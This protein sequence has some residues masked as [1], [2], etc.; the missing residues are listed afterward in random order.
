VR[1]VLVPSSALLSGLQFALLNPALALLLVVVFGASAADVGWVLAAYN[2]SGFVASLLLP[3]YADRREDYLGP[4]LA[5]GVLGVAMALLLLSTPSLPIVVLGLVTIGAPAGVG[6]SLLF[7]HLNFSGARPADVVNTRA[8]VS[9][10]WVVGP[11]LAALLVGWAGNR[12]LLLALVAVAVL[13]VAATAGLLGMRRRARRDPVDEA[14]QVVATGRTMS[15]S[16]VTLVIVAFIALQATNSAVVAIMALYVTKSLG[17]D[18]IWAGLSLGVAAA[19]EI[20]ALLVLARLDDRFSSL[21]LIG[22]GCLAGIAYYAVM[23]VVSG[24]ALLLVVQVLNAWF[25]ATIAGVGITLFQ[26]VV[27]RPGLATGLYTNTRRLGAILSGPII[28][29]GSLTLHSYAGVF[30]VCATMTL[31]AAALLAVAARSQP[32]EV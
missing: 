14:V 8:V 25:F 17:L 32:I 31:A 12:A 20:P 16:G 19:L 22:G 21:A 28:A 30:V 2:A 11:P 7:A 9:F 1:R 10:A 15:R 6:I 27:P 13:N 3:M 18:V 26:Q 4:M 29:L 24:P 5:C 23:V